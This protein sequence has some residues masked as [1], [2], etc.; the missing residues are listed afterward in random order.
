MIRKS[1]ILLCIVVVALAWSAGVASAQPNGYLRMK[2]HTVH[3][4]GTETAW[5]DVEFGAKHDTLNDVAIVCSVSPHEEDA[6]RPEIFDPDKGPF[7]IAVD[8]YGRDIVYGDY[9]QPPTLDLSPRQAYSVG[10][11]VRSLNV[12][13]GF[14]GEV[15]SVECTLSTDVFSTVIA[16]DKIVIR[17]R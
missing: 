10:F 13:A 4:S 1:L 16:S 11:S 6:M 8:N 7:T 3:L 9:R 14:K 5:I 15:G 2:A 12:P 17:V